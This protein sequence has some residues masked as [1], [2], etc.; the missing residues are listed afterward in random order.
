MSVTEPWVL[1]CGSIAIDFVGQYNGSFANYQDRYEINALNISLQLSDLRTSF[2]GCGMNITY[3]LHKLSI[4]VI[5]LT[6]AGANYMDHYHQHLVEMG[7]D[8]AYIAVDAS[9][10]RCATALVISDKNGNQITGFHAGA[11]PS[12]LRKLPS[13]IEGISHCR[14]AI[15]AP[16][17]APIMLRQARDLAS[18]RVPIVF[19]P[20]QGISEFS[21]TQIRELLE[22][23]STT[24][25]NSHEFEILQH[26]A[27]LSTEEIIG[28]QDKLIVTRGINGV[29]IY[30]S[31]KKLHVPGV[32]N[33]GIV[34]PTG[35]GDAF[36]A[37]YIYGLMKDYNPE[38]C[39]RVGCVMAAV[40]LESIDTQTFE[41][42]A[43]S[44]RARYEK[45][46]GMTI[47]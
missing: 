38:V 40:N 34:D 2:G 21:K 17:D 20:G 41:I 11:S 7:I 35:C 12:L 6:A 16:E 27:E 14:M 15:L 8:T 47:V 32:E 37:G 5:P 33:V 28:M 45:A 19:D 4:P 46:Y 9:L 25:A 43:A 3:G 18:L 29:D 31:G 39:A 42:D 44:L 30:E 13:E 26:N 22:L 10:P 24:I 36:R 23:S 1:V